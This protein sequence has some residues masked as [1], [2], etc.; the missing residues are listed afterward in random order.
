MVAKSLSISFSALL[1]HNQ[2]EALS[3]A[4]SILWAAIFLF[5]LI[6]TTAVS[7]VQTD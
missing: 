4:S 3:A 6:E 2:Q 5:F 1:L 7:I